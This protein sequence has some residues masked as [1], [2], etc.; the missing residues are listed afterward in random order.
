MY[1]FYRGANPRVA[2]ETKVEEA[3]AARITEN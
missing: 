3:G 1:I 2:S